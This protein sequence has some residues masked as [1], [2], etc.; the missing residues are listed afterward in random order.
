MIDINL[1]R[2]KPEEIKKAVTAKQLDPTLVDK[3]LLTDK[4]WRELSTQVESLRKERNVVSKNYSPDNIVKAKQIKEELKKLESQLSEVEKENTLAMSALPNLFSEDTPIGKDES[5]NQVLRKWGEPTKFGF[6]PKNHMQLG[7]SL[8]I[9]DTDKAAK[10]SGSRFNFL[11]GDAVLLQF[12]LIQFVF[13]T[14][15]NKAIIEEL[16]QKAGCFS[17]K[18]F[19]LVVPPVFV[20]S[21]VMKK[22]DRFDPIDER[23]YLDKDDLVLVGS[24]C[25]W[26]G[27]NRY[28]QKTPV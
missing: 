23:Y 25:I 10:I 24:W 15:T 27:H 21:E 18:P 16:S 5:E 2:E 19:T 22:M 8:G 20:R 17:A 9:I 6:Q 14:L 12:A 28:I 11:F 26:Q 4:K 13:E 3:A 7:V 1:L